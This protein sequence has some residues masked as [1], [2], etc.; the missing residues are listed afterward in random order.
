MFSVRTYSEN[1]FPTKKIISISATL[2]IKSCVPGNLWEWTKLWR[3]VSQRKSGQYGTWCLGR[4]RRDTWY[5]ELY[6]AADLRKQL[7]FA[8]HRLSWFPVDI[9]RGADTLKLFKLNAGAVLYGQL[10]GVGFSDLRISFRG[11]ILDVSARDSDSEGTTCV[12]YRVI[13]SRTTPLPAENI[14]IL[15]SVFR[16][17]LILLYWKDEPVHTTFIIIA[18]L[19]P[20]PG[21]ESEFFAFRTRCAITPAANVFT[22]FP[23]PLPWYITPLW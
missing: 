10:F 19:P 18:P 12:L 3:S 7:G 20:A 14:Q 16:Q 13:C 5:H 9:K 23:V 22:N 8:H 2:Y 21:G 6:A 4:K 17:F 15:L 11:W 1:Y